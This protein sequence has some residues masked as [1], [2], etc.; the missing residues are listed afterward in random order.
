MAEF[1]GGL[2]DRV[3][4][5]TATVS[6]MVFK[7]FVALFIGL[8]LA[9]I[10]DEALKYGWFSFILMLVTFTVIF[11]RV[12]KSWGASHVAIFSVICVLIGVVLRMYILIAPG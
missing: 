4:S 3:K 9:L 11:L 10:G 2:Q 12:M 7:A 8:T 5:S 6:L 1:V